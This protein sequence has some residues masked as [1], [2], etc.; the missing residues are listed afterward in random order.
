MLEEMVSNGVFLLIAALGS[1]MSGVVLT[2]EV[3]KGLEQHLFNKNS[4]H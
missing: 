4:Q 1:V 3:I 2:T